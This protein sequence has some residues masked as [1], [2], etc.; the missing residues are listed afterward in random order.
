MHACARRHIVVNDRFGVY[1]CI[2]R[3]V[4]GAFPCGVDPTSGKDHEHLKHW[5]CERL[6]Q[7][8]SILALDICGYAV[9]SNHLNVVLRSQP[10]LVQDWTDE[11]IA[12]RSKRLYPPTDPSTGSSVEPADY[13]LN[14]IDS[15]P[16]RVAELRSRLS[17]L[18]WFMRRL[19]EPIARRANRVDMGALADS[20]MCGSS[21]KRYSMKRRS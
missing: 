6:Q 3:C 8:A 21:R 13:D 11:E 20:G 1:H 4:R 9:M 19:S 14:M 18:S 7:L 2:A 10:D 15:S 12:L 5:I 17:S 16:E